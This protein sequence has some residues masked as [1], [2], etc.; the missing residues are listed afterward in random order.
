MAWTTPRTWVTNEIVTA[1]IMNAHVRD[2]LLEGPAATVSAA[3]ALPYADTANSVNSEL[4]IGVAGSHLASTGSAPVWRDT[5]GAFG[6]SGAFTFTQTVFDD[7]DNL[8]SGS[9][10]EDVIVTI[11]TGVN[12]LILWEG[13]MSNA[14]AGQSTYLGFRTSGAT[15]IAAS[16]QRCIIYESSNANDTARMTGHYFASSGTTQ[17][18]AGSNTFT[19]VGRV[20]GGTGSLSNT[21]LTVIPF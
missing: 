4:L 11:T 20:T 5:D 21:R 15:T 18:T 3:G 8:G 12:A 16:N 2:N 13:T 9:P 10:G 19:L 17:L 1:A 6:N 14:S 7:L